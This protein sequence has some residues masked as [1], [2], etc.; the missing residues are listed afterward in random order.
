MIYGYD[1]RTINS[2]GLKEMREI[3]FSVA[4]A[5]LRR[6]AEFLLASAEAL[7]SPRTAN[8]HAHIS[9][10]VQAQIECDIVVLRP[11]DTESE[12]IAA[13]FCDGRT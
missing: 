1:N 3:A 8:W 12:I 11:P 13:P 9:K 7:E 10:S 5:D 2:Y 6:I 4:A